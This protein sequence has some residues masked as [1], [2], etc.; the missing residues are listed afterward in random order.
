MQSGTDLK[1]VPMNSFLTKADLG[2]TGL[3]SCRHGGA[4]GVQSSG[5]RLGGKASPS[6]SSRH[7]LGSAGLGTYGVT[8]GSAGSPSRG[9]PWD[10]HSLRESAS[11]LSSG[12]HLVHTMQA[13]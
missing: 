1:T 8:A 12:V 5:E 6:A 3:A 7:F 10:A 11:L 9:S 2:H 4:G 13:L